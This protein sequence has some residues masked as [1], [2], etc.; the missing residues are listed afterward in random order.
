MGNP[1]KKP[2]LTIGIFYSMGKVLS[3]KIKIPTEAG[4]RVLRC[5]A[6]HAGSVAEST[7]KPLADIVT[8]YACRE[9][10]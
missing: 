10:D 9:R 3:Y 4:T 8:N 5:N 6:N 1:N 2:R 7:L